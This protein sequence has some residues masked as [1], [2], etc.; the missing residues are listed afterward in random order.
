MHQ[1]QKTTASTRAGILSSPE[2]SRA[3][4]L[5]FLAA[6]A[7]VL[8]FAWTPAPPDL[9]GN[10]KSQ[11][12]LAF[13]LLTILFRTGFPRLGWRGTLIWMGVLGAVIEFVQAIPAL[14]RDCDI[15]DWFADMAAVAIGLVAVGLVTRLTG[16]R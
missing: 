5:M 1:E 13:T 16:R 3:A 4:R 6:L 11:H 15:Y 7:G 10:D 8:Y 9:I 2:M 14:H 12:M